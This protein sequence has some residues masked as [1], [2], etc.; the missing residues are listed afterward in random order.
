[1]CSRSLTRLGSRLIGPDPN[2]NPNHS[3]NP[4]QD[5]VLSIRENARIQGFPDAYAFSGCIYTRYRQVGKSTSPHVYYPVSP[6][7]PYTP[8]TSL[9]LL[10]QLCDPLPLLSVPLL[11]PCTVPRIPAGGQPYYPT[12]TPTAQPLTRWATR[13]RPGWRRGSACRYCAHSPASHRTTIHP[14]PTPRSTVGCTFTN[15][16]VLAIRTAYTMPSVCPRLTALSGF[17]TAT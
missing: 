2:P 11:Y 3:P 8:P 12:P 14:S 7:T 13:S 16:A 17:H 5:R 10:P 15:N 6:Y 1:V 4:N 9:R